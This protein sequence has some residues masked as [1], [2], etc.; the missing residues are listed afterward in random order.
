[1]YYWLFSSCRR[2]SAHLEVLLDPL[3]DIEINGD[4]FKCAELLKDPGG[5][6]WKSEE[7]EEALAARLRNYHRPYLDAMEDLQ[8]CM[9][10]LAKETRVED[11]QFQELLSERPD[12]T[13]QTQF[14][15]RANVIVKNS[16]FQARR[17]KYSILSGSRTELIEE[18]NSRIRGLRQLVDDIDKVSKSEEEHLATPK[19]VPKE[20]LSF[21]GH[22]ERIYRLLRGSMVCP[23]RSK[24]GA[25]LW[26][27]HNTKREASLSLL[28]M[29]SRFEH[30]DASPWAEEALRVN[31]VQDS[32]A[33][34]SH[35]PSQS[36][37]SAVL[38]AR[39]AST[40]IFRSPGR[41]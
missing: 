1:M 3:A 36:V 17:L 8:E 14:M 35:V 5:D 38:Q 22:A 18:V 16:T 21:W 41:G 27:C 29:F 9:V 15:Q 12:A 31:L 13:A 6:L 39:T 11:A 40:S 28:M 7:V 23:C 20:L 10:K 33:P 32:T 19:R 26:L 37:P 34:D 4:E 25:R 2:F 24:H 30:C